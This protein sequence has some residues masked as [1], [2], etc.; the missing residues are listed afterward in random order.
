[1]FVSDLLCLFVCSQDVVVLRSPLTKDASEHFY[2]THVWA[3]LVW[4]CQQVQ[5]ALVELEEEAQQAQVEPGL[6]TK[7]KKKTK[8]RRGWRVYVCV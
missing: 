4:G 3:C 8:S 2:W 5:Q 1:M 6:Q 7:K